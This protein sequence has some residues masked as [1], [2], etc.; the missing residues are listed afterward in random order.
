MFLIGLTGGIAS[1]KSSVCR[2][3]EELGVPVVDADLIA[4]EVVQIGTPAYQRIQKEFGPDVFQVSGELDRGKLGAVIFTDEEKRKLI[5]SITHPQI[6]S[7]MKRQV[8][9]HFING[10]QMVVLDLPLLFETG[11]ALPYIYKTIVVNCDPEEQLKRLQARGGYT[12]RQAKERIECQ[13]PLSLKTAR[14][15]FVIENSGA[16]QY[17]RSQVEDIVRTLRASKRHVRNKILLALAALVVL[18]ATCWLLSVL[19]NVVARRTTQLL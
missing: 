1:G 7:K 8:F 2:I 16:R 3:L 12:E 17:T 19:I 4:R 6:Y 14:A 15:D 5:N 10:E 11:K 18:A 9:R 13:M